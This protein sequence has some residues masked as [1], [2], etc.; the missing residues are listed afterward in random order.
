MADRSEQLRNKAQ[1]KK[2][3]FINMMFTLA[4]ALQG[5]LF[6]IQEQLTQEVKSEVKDEKIKK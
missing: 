1:Q 4:T 3:N 2:D 5:D 6:E